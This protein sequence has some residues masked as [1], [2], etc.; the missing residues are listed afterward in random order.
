MCDDWDTSYVEE[1]HQNY[2][3]AQPNL[4]WFESFD[5]WCKTGELD[6][7][8]TSHIIIEAQ[9]IKYMLEHAPEKIEGWED[10]SIQEIND[11][12]QK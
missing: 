1:Y 6:E 10:L 5:N 9:L 4:Q 7:Y 8:L 12:Y 3:N 2:I 11:L